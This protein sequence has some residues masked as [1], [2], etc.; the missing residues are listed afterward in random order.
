MKPQG[1]ELQRGAK[2][3]TNQRRKYYIVSRLRVYH[4]SPQAYYSL[5][6]YRTARQ[7]ANEREGWNGHAYD[8]VLGV[9]CW[10]EE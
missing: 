2:L 3:C 8:F 4:A 10:N 5:P 1:R 7:K 9:S 6:D